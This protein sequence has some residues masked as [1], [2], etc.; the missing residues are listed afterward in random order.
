M[1]K[2]D[3]SFSKNLLAFNCHALGISSTSDDDFEWWEQN[4]GWKSQFGWNFLGPEKSLSDAFQFKAAFN[5]TNE[6]KTFQVIL[7]I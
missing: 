6:M 1:F 4:L 7:K 5:K 3:E 2:P